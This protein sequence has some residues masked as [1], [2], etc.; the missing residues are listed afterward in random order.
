ML[1]EQSPPNSAPEHSLGAFVRRCLLLALILS[2]TGCAQ[3]PKLPPLPT[4]ANLRA[5][6]KQRMDVAR[7][8]ENHNNLAEARHV[9][10]TVLERNPKQREAWHRLA[11]IAAREAK[12]A[13]AEDH[14]R[15]VAELG[16]MTPQILCDMG[17]TLYLQ[18]RLPESEQVLRDAL[19]MEP[20]NKSAANNLALVLGQQGRYDEC[21]TMFKQTNSE[22]QAEANLAYVLTQ[23]GQTKLAQ[24]HYSRALSLDPEMRR[25]AQ[26]LLQLAKAE[27]G[28]QAVAP[29]TDPRLTAPPSTP[30][31]GATAGGASAQPPAAIYGPYNGTPANAAP[32]QQYA[33]QM[34]SNVVAPFGN[35]NPLGGIPAQQPWQ[36]P[37]G[38]QVGYTG[39]AQQPAMPIPTTNT[40]P[41]QPGQAYNAQAVYA[42]QYPGANGMPASY[43]SQQYA[44]QASNQQP[45]NTV[46][47]FYVVPAGGGAAGTTNGTPYGSPAQRN[48]QN[49][50][51]AGFPAPFVK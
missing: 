23:M 3:L 35:P 19:A 11:V 24:A 10:N 39:A 45:M 18:H 46:Q 2:F 22:A 34:S 32:G 27:G 6:E 43:P 5:K 21:L 50:L 26:A 40:V 47:P 37:P 31:P 38:Q 9:Y 8:A 41:G 29:V 13:E 49:N 7:L 4:P 28:G 17:Y 36:A 44:P 12:W 33:Q 42:P 14:Y 16:P 1:S 15:R 51:P 30:A 48:V 25:A 20:R